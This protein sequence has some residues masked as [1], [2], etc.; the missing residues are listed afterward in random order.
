MYRYLAGRDGSHPFL[1]L[2]QMR[3]ASSQLTHL[4]NPVARHL[5][6]VPVEPR[7]LSAAGD[8]STAFTVE[9]RGDLELGSLVERHHSR[10]PAELPRR[11]ADWLRVK[12][13]LPR[14]QR[15]QVA[16]VVSVEC[17]CVAGDQ[18]QQ[19]GRICAAHQPFDRVEQL[20][21]LLG[22]GVEFGRHR[23]DFGQLL[24]Q[25]GVEAGAGAGLR[26]GCA[27]NRNDADESLFEEFLRRV[28]HAAAALLTQVALQRP[29]AE[30]Q[31]KHTAWQVKVAGHELNQLQQRPG[32]GH[33]DALH[34]HHQR[35]LRHQPVEQ[36][37]HRGVELAHRLH[38]GGAVRHERELVQPLHQPVGD[39][40]NSIVAVREVLQ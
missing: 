8:I 34:Q 15:P 26:G 25:P 30:R 4:E 3:L 38:A 18:L 22:Q 16:V 17:N 35:R 5:V 10:P 14:E 9:P 31:Y 28:G 39:F 7:A 11:R 36:L 23:P 20:G 2:L 21:P 6:A 12:E 13:G 40:G 33:I 27:A 37:P 19:L 32:S 29:L 24:L 1:S